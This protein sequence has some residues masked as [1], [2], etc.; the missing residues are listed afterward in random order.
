MEEQHYMI[1]LLMVYNI[2]KVFKNK[3]HLHE[4]L[5]KLLLMAFLILTKSIHNSK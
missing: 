4:Y 3:I 5:S 1:V 2:W